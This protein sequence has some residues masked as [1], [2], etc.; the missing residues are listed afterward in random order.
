MR[1]LYKRGGYN[2]TPSSPSRRRFVTEVVQQS[3]CT[4]HTLTGMP[5][6]A[7]MASS[8]VILRVSLFPLIRMQILAFQKLQEASSDLNSLNHL[9]KTRVKFIQ[10]TQ[11]SLF[12]SLEGRNQL[13]RTAQSY[14]SG[15]QACRILHEIPV[16]HILAPPFVNIGIFATFTYSMRKMISAVPSLGLE[17]GGMMWFTNL[18]VPDPTFTLPIVSIVLTSASVHYSLKKS[19]RKVL[20]IRYFRNFVQTG[21]I[22]S[23]PF[24]IQFPAGVFCYWIPSTVTRIA[25]QYLLENEKFRNLMTLPK[26]HHQLGL[27]E[28]VELMEQNKKKKQE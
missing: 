14:I 12:S 18:T 24:V 19:S 22:V 7:T 6:W 9:F 5:W 20:M 28:R 8:T 23:I 27:K 17:D 21:L 10:A 26:L 13:L 3:L 11:T 15:L 4:A 16:S 1:R 25:Q 2:I